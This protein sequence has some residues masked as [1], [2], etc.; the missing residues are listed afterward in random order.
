MGDLIAEITKGIQ[1]RKA[2]AKEY[3]VMDKEMDLIPN[4]IMSIKA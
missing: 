3:K 2:T 1:F 4:S